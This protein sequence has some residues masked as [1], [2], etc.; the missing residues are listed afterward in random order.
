M[1]KIILVSI[2][3]IVCI[4]QPAHTQEKVT[5][6]VGYVPLLT[7]LPLVIS[8]ENDRLN[9]LQVD[10]DLIKCTSFTSLEAALRVGAIDAASIP[11]PIALSI[12][13]DAYD[14]EWCR[15]TIL[16]TI[17]KGGSVLVAE[18]S[19]S[20]E[21]MRGKLIGVPALDSAENLLLKE[22]LATIGLRFGLDYKTIGIPFEAAI[23]TIKAGKLQG[24]YL[25][26]P[27]GTMA[28]REGIAVAV[29]GQQDYLTGTLMTV[30]VIHS[31]TMNT[32]TAAVRE[33]LMS[34]VSSCHFIEHDIQVSGGRQTA[35]IQSSYFGYPRDIV[36]ESLAQ[37]KGDLSFGHELP[38]VE[39]LQEF[40]RLASEM[41]LIMRSVDWSTLVTPEI[42]QQVLG[43]DD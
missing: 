19:S 27:F 25:P 31:E 32:Q 35:I 39:E 5:L 6:R 4:G 10:L 8:Y 16:G 21:A 37:R 17:H 14:C 29:E 24:L 42:V 7:Q 11:V 9:F 33:W 23:K 38:T 30:L 15:I 22:H 2:V 20:L 36:A 28:E 18:D 3:C 41:K 40:M 1:K 26:E 43:V 34:V 12:A 13:A